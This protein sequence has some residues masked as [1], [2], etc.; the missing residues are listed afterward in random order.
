M[1]PPHPPF[2]P[3]YFNMTSCLFPTSSGWNP[4]LLFLLTAPCVVLTRLR[5]V[6]IPFLVPRASL[7][8]SVAH[9][10]HANNC[11]RPLGGSQQ[12]H[13]PTKDCSQETDPKLNLHT[14]LSCRMTG[15]PLSLSAVSIK[16]MTNPLF[17]IGKS[18]MRALN[19]AKEI[20]TI[21]V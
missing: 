13:S 12:N 10:T 7:P 2:L 3:C 18:N 20:H 4:V 9:S 14:L 11:L 21:A 16:V 15:N 19:E 5:G 8:S 17:N 1:C 6:C